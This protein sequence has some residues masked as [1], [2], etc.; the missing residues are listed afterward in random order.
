MK[1]FIP[2]LVACLIAT[3]FS[4]AQSEISGT[5]ANH[6]KEGIHFA[7]I[8]LFNQRDSTLVKGTTSDEKG[9]FAISNIKEG[10]YY[11]E[12]SMLGFATKKVEN[13][14][15]PQDN[16]KQFTLTLS[17]DATVLSTVEVTA[18]VPLLEQKA[19]RLVVNVAENVTSLNGSLLDVMKKVPGMASPCSWA[20]V[21]KLILSISISTTA[22]S[23]KLM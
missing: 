8:A 2:T 18:K 9:Y 13:I 16:G 20:N 23:G 15:F 3:Q 7:T 6:Q 11:L 21:T 12:S 19:D 14:V 4:F 5:I 10:Q 1:R 17:E 22:S